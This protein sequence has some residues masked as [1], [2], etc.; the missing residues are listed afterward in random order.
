[1][2][3]HYDQPNQYA[4][5]SVEKI[6]YTRSVVAN[7]DM[8]TFSLS[9]MWINASLSRASSPEDWYNGGNVRLG[10]SEL[11]EAESIDKTY[12]TRPGIQW[13]YPVYTRVLEYL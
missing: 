11:K 5:A 13:K 7:V 8:D 10:C 4:F 3:I 2:D 6:S 1:M 12:V 9:R